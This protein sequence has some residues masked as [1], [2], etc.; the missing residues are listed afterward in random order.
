M[1]ENKPTD[2][3]PNDSEPTDS[4]TASPKPTDKFEE[5]YKI[6]LGVIQKS[7]LS[8][9]KTIGVMI[10][11]VVTVIATGVLFG[12]YR[13]FGLIL[14][15]NGVIIFTITRHPKGFASANTTRQKISYYGLSTCFALLGVNYLITGI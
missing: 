15:I 10:G 5:I 1:D 8:K 6:L 4:N 12:A 13:M 7:P 2:L 14:F 11:Y 3:K 9:Q